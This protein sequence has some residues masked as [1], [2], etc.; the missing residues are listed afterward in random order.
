M[1]QP[2]IVNVTDIKGNTK[3]QAITTSVVDLLENPAASGKVYRV[4]FFSVANIDGVNTAD[5]T[6]NF[7]DAS[8]TTSF[9]ICNTVPVPADATLMIVDRP[10]YLE[11]GDK[12][13]ITASAN[14]DLEAVVSWV[15]IDD[16]KI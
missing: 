11:E 3:G 1:A 16:L 10:I 14:S 5:F 4:E 9:K 13:T 7:Y 6:L 15:I 2:N 12:L 8:S